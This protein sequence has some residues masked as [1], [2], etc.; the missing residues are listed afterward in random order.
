MRILGR[1]GLQLRLP[2]AVWNLDPQCFILE[3]HCVGSLRDCGPADERPGEHDSFFGTRIF[4]DPS[5]EGVKIAACR[6]HVTE[7]PLAWQTARPRLRSGNNPVTGEDLWANRF[8]AP[9]PRA[10]EL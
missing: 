4:E 1:E 3:A 5:G 6:L 9:T 2:S 8:S 10:R 7:Q